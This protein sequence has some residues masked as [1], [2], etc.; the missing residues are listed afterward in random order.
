MKKEPHVS[1]C[2]EKEAWEE[3]AKLEAKLKAKLNRSPKRWEEE[4]DYSTRH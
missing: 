2:W 1:Y 3:E 4:L